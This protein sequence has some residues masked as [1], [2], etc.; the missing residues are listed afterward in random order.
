LST[1][2]LVGA[3]SK[4]QA[5]HHG[6]VAIDAFVDKDRTRYNLEADHG[7]SH[8]GKESAAPGAPVE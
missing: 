3:G 2:L 5:H 4:A 8:H 1:A 7:E 6:P